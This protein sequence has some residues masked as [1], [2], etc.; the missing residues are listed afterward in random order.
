[1]NNPLRTLLC[2]AL[3]ASVGLGPLACTTALDRRDGSTLR[4][5]LIGG[6][7]KYIYANED[8][9]IIAV[10]RAS[11]V[12]IDHPG[13]VPMVLSIIPFVFSLEALSINALN[14]E[15]KSNGDSSSSNTPLRNTG[16]TLAAIGVG[17]LVGG[18]I[19][20]SN[21]RQAAADTTMDALPGT[22]FE[23]PMLMGRQADPDPRPAVTPPARKPPVA[24]QPDQPPAGEPSE[25]DHPPEVRPPHDP[26]PPDP[27]PSE[28]SSNPH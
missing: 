9:K 5:D 15:F 25:R 1:M 26:V 7:K 20:W 12:D 3:I 6:D 28:D 11:I 23:K 4:V 2:G 10:P 18:Y 21:S 16:L 27:L 13:N 17:M 24:V 19:S 14:G 8:D 22:I